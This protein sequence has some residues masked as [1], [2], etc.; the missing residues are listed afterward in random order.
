MRKKKDSYARVMR[1]IE[2]CNEHGQ[3]FSV[4]THV[5]KVTRDRLYIDALESVLKNSSKIM[6]DVEGGNNMMY[7]PLDQLTRRAGETPIQI[8]QSAVDTAVERIL[9]EVNA[10]RSNNTRIRGGN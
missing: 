8:D 7:L 9:R 5:S 10:A 6:V 1:A 2:L 3:P 4:V